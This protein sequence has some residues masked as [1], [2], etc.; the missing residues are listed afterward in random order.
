MSA[1][2]Y[3]NRKQYE[4]EVL[5]KAAELNHR[6]T[7]DLTFEE[8]YILYLAAIYQEHAKWDKSG[9]CR[10]IFETHLL[11][12]L[13][14][15]RLR[16]IQEQEVYDVFYR[17]CFESGLSVAY[18]KDVYNLLC[19]DFKY[20]VLHGW[21]EKIPMNRTRIRSMFMSV[22]NPG[23]AE[24]DR[25]RIIEYFESKT[26]PVY[27]TARIMLHSGIQLGELLVLQKK[28]WNSET[29]EVNVTQRIKDMTRDLRVVPVTPA[30]VL[31]TD[32]IGAEL[33][34]VHF[35]RRDTYIEGS[36]ADCRTHAYSLF[37][38]TKD[39]SIELGISS[40]KPKLLSAIGAEVSS[41]SQAL[42]SGVS[43][44]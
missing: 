21:I 5:A 44:N 11:K 39:A 38:V 10:T 37:R 12:P 25:Q 41:E 14:G 27:E 23:L 42:C 30:R 33:L 3:K 4:K 40:L 29:K 31:R 9:F 32:A 19:N 34:E 8:G 1:T 28:N 36:L 35:D 26:G 17:I 18:I 2:I 22:E 24:E 15:R 13:E 16:S 7:D 20:A 6:G 43:Y